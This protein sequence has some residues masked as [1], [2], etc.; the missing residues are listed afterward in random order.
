MGK[1]VTVSAKQVTKRFD[2]AEKQSDKLKA[3]FKF[4]GDDVPN[5]WALKGVSFEAKSGETIGV[6]GTNGSGKSTLLEMVAGVREPTS[7]SLE[8]NGKTSIISVGA[9]MRPQL[10]GR[11]NIRLKALLQ[12]MTEAQIDDKMEDII[13]FSELGDFI[14]QPVKSYSSGMKSK[15][16]FAISAYSDS[17]IVIID[18]ALSVGD[19]TFTE[20]S[21][22]RTK[23]FKEEGKTI[24]F[25]AHSSSQMRQVADRVLWM[26]HGNLW[27]DGPIDVVLPEYERFVKRFQKFSETE[28]SAYFLHYKNAQK[29]FSLKKLE[30]LSANTKMLKPHNNDGENQTSQNSFKEED[31]NMSILTRFI[32]GVVIV[33][34]AGLMAKQIL[35][36]PWPTFGFGDKPKVEE[37]NKK[38]SSV[39]KENNQSSMSSGPTTQS[40]ESIKT[41]DIIQ[42][43]Y[44]VQEPM[45]LTELSVQTG[46]PVD[47]LRSINQLVDENLQPGQKIVLSSEE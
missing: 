46:I 43:Q 47:T 5:F 20:K 14:D 25:V 13:A 41:Q 31:G 34:T 6:I 27:M 19:Q 17:D 35:N 21:I 4:W 22:E 40:S 12:G 38:T 7:G 10:T 16:G 18:E 2:L 44:T 1:K 37:V 9:G 33:G 11:A 26:H 45:T 15:L 23:R 29:A 42:N 30:Q 36:V 3:V 24:F 28:R 8:V 32:L 39:K